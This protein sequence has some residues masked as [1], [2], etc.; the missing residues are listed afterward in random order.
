MA[1]DF[2]PKLSLLDLAG[3]KAAVVQK[4]AEA[5]DYLFLMASNTLR[6]GSTVPEE[7]STASERCSGRS[8]SSACRC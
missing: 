3:T 1:S 5:K 8:G 7:V 2:A 6:S 4:R